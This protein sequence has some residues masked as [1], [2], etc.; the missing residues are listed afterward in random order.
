MSACCGASSGIGKAFQEIDERPTIIF[1][2]TEA[3]DFSEYAVAW[4]ILYHRF[5][6]DGIRKP[7]AQLA[8][9]QIT[10]VVHEL[11][12]Y[13]RWDEKK[14]AYLRYPSSN[15]TFEVKEVST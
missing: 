10:A 3:L 11:F 7:T 13:R 12:I 9:Q 15:K 2:S 4:S 1:G 5:K 8:L 6:T 14:K